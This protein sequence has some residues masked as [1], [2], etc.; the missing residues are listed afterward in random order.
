MAPPLRQDS[1][2]RRIQGGGITGTGTRWVSRNSSGQF[3][4]RRAERSSVASMASQEIRLSSC[5]PEGGAKTA[6]RGFSQTEESKQKSSSR[7][8]GVEGTDTKERDATGSPNGSS[9]V[10]RAASWASSTVVQ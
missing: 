9:S 10:I 1:S 8:D 2:S 5:N 7:L 4:A 6:A 3:G